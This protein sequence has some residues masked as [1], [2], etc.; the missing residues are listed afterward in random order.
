[1][2]EVGTL[3]TLEWHWG[4]TTFHEVIDGNV[5]QLAEAVYSED[6]WDAAPFLI[7]GVCAGGKTKFYSDELLIESHFFA[8]T[9]EPGS[10]PIAV[11]VFH[12]LLILN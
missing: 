1:M 4:R 11:S 8:L 6:G 5:Y 12:A 2:H 9:P 7:G 3:K 10:H